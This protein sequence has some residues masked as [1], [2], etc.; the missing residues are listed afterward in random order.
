[1]THFLV[2]CKIC[3]E[4]W[5]DHGGYNVCKEC[6]IHYEKITDALVKNWN[7]ITKKEFDLIVAAIIPRAKIKIKDKDKNSMKIIGIQINS[8]LDVIWVREEKNE[9]V[10]HISNKRN[11][12]KVLSLTYDEV[13]A[14]ASAVDIM[15]Q[16][17]KGE[18]SDYI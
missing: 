10:F 13:N 2:N 6:L 18:K 15:M 17:E 5:P 8:E 16:S 1:M 11:N 14:V 4:P 7:N 12:L 9:I 3:E